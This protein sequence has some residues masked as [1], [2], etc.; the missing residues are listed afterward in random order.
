MSYD[1]IHWKLE[2]FVMSPERDNWSI[3]RLCLWFWPLWIAEFLLLLLPD[4]GAKR[5][6]EKP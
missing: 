5:K 1:D 6:K 3:N 4:R 2:M